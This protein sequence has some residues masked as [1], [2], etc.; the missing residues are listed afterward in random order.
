MNSVLLRK[1]IGSERLSELLQS[2]SSRAWNRT[3]GSLM[4]KARFVLNLP[5]SKFFT[6]PFIRGSFWKF[7]CIHS[8]LS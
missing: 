6:D 1:K 7:L 4:S 3:W 8:I 2:A 5:V